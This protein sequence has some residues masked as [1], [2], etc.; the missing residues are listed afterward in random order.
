NNA[1]KEELSEF[2]VV[3]KYATTGNIDTNKSVVAKIATTATDGKVYQMEYFNLDMVL[4]VGY[5]VKSNRGIQF[6]AWANSVLKNF[7]LKG[8]AVEMRFERLENR[9]FETEK[10]I[11]FFVN[12]ALP[13][14]QGIFFDGQVFDAYNLATDIFRSARHSSVASILSAISGLI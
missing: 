12:T 8:Y 14:V 7:V 1:L 6:R 10:K 13:P 3:A 11:D 9:V 4:S 5:R 2:S